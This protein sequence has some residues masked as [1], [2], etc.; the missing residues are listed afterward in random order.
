MRRAAALLLVVLAAAGWLAAASCKKSKPESAPEKGATAVPE[1]PEERAHEDLP[2]LVKLTPEVIREAHVRTEPARKRT[3]AATAELSGQIVPNPE[4]LA[5]I[6]A[7][8]SGRIL[9]VLVREADL[10]RP[11]QVLA[12]LSSP[13]I[14]IAFKEPFTLFIATCPVIGAS[15]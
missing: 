1:H 4:A 5:L 2:K 7:R 13:E 6:G 11:G 10:V 14:P 15:I 8:A 9:R 3:L 12:I